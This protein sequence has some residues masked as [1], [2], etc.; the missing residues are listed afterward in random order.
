MAFDA[1]G[2]LYVAVF[3]QGDVTVL[4]LDGNVVRRLPTIGMLPTNVAFALPGQ[5]RIHVTEY[6]KGRM[7]TFAVGCDG[8]SLWDGLRR[9]VHGELHEPA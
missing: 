9:E 4:G 7:E 2:L 6:E 5:H 8:L 3:A 1:N